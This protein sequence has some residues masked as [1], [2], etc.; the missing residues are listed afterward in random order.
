MSPKRRYL[1]LLVL[2]GFIGYMLFSTYEEVRNKTI[3]EFNIQQMILAKQAAR[4][5]ESF[6]RSYYRDLAFL[7]GVED[8]IACGD[9]GKAAM[10]SYHA[11]NSSEIR[12]ITRVD[13]NGKIIYTVP[14]NQEAIGADISYQE[15]VRTIMKTHAPVVSE[16]FKAVQG[17]MAVAYHVPVL[18]DG[19]FFGSLAVLI[20]FEKIAGNSMEN[21]GA[22][23]DGYACIISQKGVELYCTVPGHSGQTVFENS[24]EFPSVIAM[25]REMMDGKSGTTTFVRD[26]P[27]EGKIEKLKFQAVYHPIRLGSTFWSIA[28]ATPERT[29]LATMKG[30]RNRLFFLVTVLLGIGLF[31]SY[32]FIQAL[33]VLREEKIRK[34]AEDALRRSEEKY[35]DLADSLPQIVFETDNT[36]KLTFANRVAFKW[37]GY[38]REEFE[39]GLDAVRMVA[40][41]DRQRAG[42][43]MLKVMS[44]ENLG[45]V[46]YLMQT[47]N[48]DTFP[49]L[50]YSSLIV[51]EGEAEGLRGI[52]ADLSEIRKAEAALRS[53][54]QKFRALV[55]ESPVGVAM[56]SKAGG[57]EYVNPKFTELFGYVREEIAT[58]REWFEKAFPD[59]KYRAEVISAWL[60]DL[61]TLNDGE[62][63]TITFNV[64][65]KDGSVKLIHFRPVSLSAGGQ[66]VTYEDITEIKRLEAQFQQVQRMEAIGT[67]AGGIAHDFNNLLMGIQGRTS[68]MLTDVD[69]F[70]PLHEHLE[71]IEEYVKS[72][73]DLTKQLLGF[74]RG[75]KY[76][77]LPTDLNDLIKRQNRMFSRTK[78]EISVRGKYEKEIWSV[79]VDRG[80]MDQVILN[81][82]VNAW[83]AMP[84]G[85]EL[86]VQTQNVTLGRIQIRPFE[87]KPGRYVKI[88]VTD[89]GTGM[90]EAIRQRI[91]DPFFTTKEMGRGTGMG[92]ASVYGIIKNH[93]GFID[94]FSKK[95]EGSTF[96]IHIPAV[97]AVSHTQPRERNNQVNNI[98]KGSGSVLLVDDE[99]M[100]VDVGGQML[101]ALGYT[102]LTAG[103][104]PDA[105][106]LY[107]KNREKIDI[108]ILDMV[109]PGMGGGETFD[110]L[111]EINPG[112]KVILS[113][114]YSI[115]GDA[116]E[117]MERGCSG[118][119]QKPFN[120][121]GL[122]RK[123]KEILEDNNHR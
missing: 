53:E 56:I 81:L 76:E 4:G 2:M 13:K 88:S 121:N 17:Y 80:Q 6:F 49:G 36:G 54:E 74:G 112:I 61:K 83:Q 68:M 27:I 33:T 99:E 50:I 23:K 107:Q 90:G 115:D 34:R 29:V 55:E 22:G 92:L 39:M 5:I 47:Q 111:K 12:A 110:K 40:P 38:S 11:A 103:N 35:R 20:P 82:Y 97:E 86:Y 66:L 117:I 15:H 57:Y 60:D 104:G 75:G 67:L 45:G 26:L 62:T 101:Q 51:R 64:T 116:S 42:E 94:V 14:Y 59:R 71:G 114:G 85:G 7:A 41:Q 30:F 98:S 108:V 28:V 16:V 44:G 119:I 84:D 96:D 58:G 70:H 3:A 32:Y 10:A 21:I 25:A 105:L 72:A 43:N 87:V 102:V 52:I 93:G 95:G 19:E 120:L 37:F 9:H 24:A 79:A 65:C 106:E 48:G 118:F 73:S 1:Y 63:R 77:V 123:V 8:M 69:A 113:S 100:I 122:S 18:L 91:F 31:Y 78:K 89:T 109:M 46:E